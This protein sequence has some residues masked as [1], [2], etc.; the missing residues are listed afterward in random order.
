MFWTE[1]TFLT[2]A[3]IVALA[4]QWIPVRRGPSVPSRIRFFSALKKDKKTSEE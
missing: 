1:P 4:I 2:T 3:L